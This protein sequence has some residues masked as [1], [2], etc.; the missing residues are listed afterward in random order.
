[1]RNTELTLAAARRA[2]NPV[3]LALRAGPAPLGAA[4]VAA[5]VLDPHRLPATPSAEWS[6]LGRRVRRWLS[7]LVER[8]PRATPA[9]TPRRA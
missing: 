8:A 2:E 9:G 4:D 5:G 7:S 6:Q 3:S 1:M